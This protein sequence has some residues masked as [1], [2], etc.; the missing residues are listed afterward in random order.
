MD[1]G[2]VLTRQIHV[3]R[4]TFIYIWTSLPTIIEQKRAMSTGLGINGN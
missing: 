3:A 4:P 1:I 2:I